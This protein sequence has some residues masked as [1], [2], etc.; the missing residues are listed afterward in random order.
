MEV[1]EAIERKIETY[2]IHPFAE[3]IKGKYT[4]NT[5]GIL[6]LAVRLHSIDTIRGCRR[7]YPRV[8]GGKIYRMIVISCRRCNSMKW[9]YQKI[10][11]YNIHPFA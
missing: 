3:S 2:N 8:G 6:F 11:T 9:K 1:C 7:H 10:E 5:Y 4:K